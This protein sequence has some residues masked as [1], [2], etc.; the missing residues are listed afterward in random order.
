MGLLWLGKDG[1]VVVGLGT[2]VGKLRCWPGGT[3]GSL[4]QGSSEKGA[5]GAPTFAERRINQTVR[6]RAAAISRWSAVSRI[7][8]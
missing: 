3:V 6:R 8:R 7:D 2:L 4:G 1:K 5:V